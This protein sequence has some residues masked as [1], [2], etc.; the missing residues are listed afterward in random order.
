MQITICLNK[1]A[2]TLL[3]GWV[4]SFKYNLYGSRFFISYKKHD[5]HYLYRGALLVA[6]GQTYDEVVKLYTNVM[7]GYSKHVRPVFDQAS[8][9]KDLNEVEGT[10]T[11]HFSMQYGWVDEK[12]SYGN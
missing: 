2:P 4:N 1:A 9:I 7:T 10:I 12:K 6:Y 8:F 11:I 5:T 3:A